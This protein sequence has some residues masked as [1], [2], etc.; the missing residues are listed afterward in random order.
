M[1]YLF[2]CLKKR[3]IVHDVVGT[4]EDL[5]EAVFFKKQSR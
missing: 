4:S 2:A 1:A 5:R 3:Q